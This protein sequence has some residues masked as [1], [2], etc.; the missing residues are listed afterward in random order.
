MSALDVT[1]VGK[2]YYM[3]ILHEI[4]W[5][6]SEFAFNIPK[7]FSTPWSITVISGSL[8]TTWIQNF[9]IQ[10]AFFLGLFVYYV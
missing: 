8:A 6:Y 5:W 7:I 1:E 9:H 4:E 10:L 3:Y 2:T